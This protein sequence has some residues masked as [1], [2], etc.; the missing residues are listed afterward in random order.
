MLADAF[1]ASDFDGWADAYD[2]DVQSPDVFP[3]AGYVEVMGEVVKQAAPALGISVLD[4]GIGTG[5][6]AVRFADLGCHVWGVDFSEAMLV[7][8][9]QKLPGGRL[10]LHDLREPWP[11]ELERRFHRVV[12][13]YTFHHFALDYKV[14]LSRLLVTRHLEPG[15]CLLIADISFQTASAMRSFAAS[16]GDLWEE[17]QYWLA[18]EALHALREAGMHAEYCQVSPCAGV[19]RI[20]QA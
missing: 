4:V 10:V 1:P 20:E 3:F 2:S 8:A 12:S 14:S 9:R 11:P 18:D 15:G 13:G 5:N 19:Y 16:T 17:E 7:K 6:L